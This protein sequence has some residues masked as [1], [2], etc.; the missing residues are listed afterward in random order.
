MNLD[1]N[2]D[3]AI[4]LRGD[5]WYPNLSDTAKVYVVD[6]TED[7]YPNLNHFPQQ[8][9]SRF[10]KDPSDDKLYAGIK[11]VDECNI[12][13]I[14]TVVGDE[15][16]N[17]YANIITENIKYINAKGETYDLI[18]DIKNFSFKLEAEDGT[19]LSSLGI[20]IDSN[21]KIS[22]NAKHAWTGNIRIV[23]TESKYG[24]QLRTNYFNCKISRD[25]STFLIIL[26]TVIGCVTL[27]GL[28]ILII[29]L[30]KRKKNKKSKSKKRK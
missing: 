12:N 8:W 25:M 29:L 28:I 10:P 16:T 18:P 4:T 6:G 30:V 26:G 15:F 22:I 2:E 13:N 9:L 14:S 21:G 7:L 19:D 20:T 24:Y 5:S 27:I 1:S 3:G 11:F 17:D 23:I